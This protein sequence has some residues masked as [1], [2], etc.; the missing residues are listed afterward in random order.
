VQVVNI[1]IAVYR[2]IKLLCVVE[3]KVCQ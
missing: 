2:P 1:H 3:S